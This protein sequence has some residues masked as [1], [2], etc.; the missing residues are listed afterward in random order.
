[1]GGPVNIVLMGAATLL[2]ARSFLPAHPPGARPLDAVWT[3]ALR[4]HASVLVLRERGDGRVIGYLPADPAVWV[5]GGRRDGRHVSIDL[6]SDDGAHAWT[7]RFDGDLGGAGLAGAAVFSDLGRQ[8]VHLRRTA[9]PVRLEHWIIADTSEGRA[10]RLPRVLDGGGHLAAGGYVQSEGCGFLGCS[11]AVTAWTVAGLVHTL[12]VVA[13]PDCPSPTGLTATWDPAQLLVQDGHWTRAALPCRAGAS[14]DFFGGKEGLASFADLGETLSLLAGFLDA[15]EAESPDAV[16][17]FAAA[18]RNDGATRADWQGVLAGLY[19]SFDALQA[20]ATEIRQVVTA[21]DPEVNPMVL[22]PP[23]VEWHLTVTGVPAGGGARTIALDRVARLAG[24]QGLYYVGREGEVMAFVGNGYDAPFTVDL[25]IAAGDQSFSNYG[26]WPYGVHGGGHPEGHPGLDFEFKSGASIRAAAAGTIDRIEVNGEFAGEWNLRVAHRSAYDTRYDHA[27]ALAVG[28]ASGVAVVPGQALGL[29]G[30]TGS[31]GSHLYM[32]H[33]AVEIGIAV[34]CPVPFFSAAA[35]TL[36]DT[37]WADA[38]YN[39][40]LTEPFPCNPVDVAFPLTRVWTRTAGT[41]P[42][43]I[44]FV[45]Q[46]PHTNAYRYVLRSA[47]GTV[48]ESG[49]V[50]LLQ[51]T[52]GPAGGLIDLQPDAGPKRLGRYR[53]ISEQ[54]LIVWGATRPA[55]LAGAAAYTTA[56]P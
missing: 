7:G 25:P 52:S 37:I 3:G 34:Q 4:G 42:A 16:Q 13:A 24:E 21:N 27:G 20:S 38:A 19:A 17:A 6:A 50:S 46:D 28:V 12:S 2:I 47:V 32:T 43:R 48:V 22:Q 9:I 45:R 54:M 1:V 41:L 31:G 29:A 14:G 10:V 35:A 51:P 56:A 40:E 18:Y 33:F 53:I 15:I 26:I 30:D 36:F 44:D 23:R 11:G 39:E 49:A 8:A 5:S 55:S